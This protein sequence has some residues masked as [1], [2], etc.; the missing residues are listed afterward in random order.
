V[1][2]AVGV[3]Y[4]RSEWTAI[5]PAIQK[6]LDALKKLGDGEFRVDARTLDDKTWVVQFVRS[7]SSGKY[8][9]YDRETGTAKVWI[10]TRPALKDAPLVTMHPQEIKSRDGLTLVSYLSL[11][12]NSDENNDGKPEQ[13]VPMVLLVH[14]GPW[15]RDGFGLNRT[16]QWLANRGYAVLSVNYRASTGFGKKFLNA[17]NLEWGKKMHDDLIDAVDWAVKGGIT[18]QD[19]VAIMGGSYGGYATLA[20]LTM[21]PKTF[22]CGVDIVGPSNLFTLL[23][24]IPPYWASFRK[25]FYTRMGDPNTDE[26]K[27]ILKDRSPLTYADKIE[28]PLLIGQGQNDPRVNVAEVAADRGRDEGEEHPGD[29][30]RVSGRGPRL[31]ASAQQHLVQLDRRELPGQ[32]PGRPLGADRRGL[33]GLEHHHSRGREPAAGRGRS[34]GREPAAGAGGRSEAR[35]H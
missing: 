15:A 21:T 13:P 27:A 7:D 10:D 20:G 29:L 4:L 30:R 31:R 8:Y 18:S 6:D 3:N 5:D 23:N 12:K 1:V 24:S 17:G 9:L 33:Q 35:G 25:Q 32:V 14:G 16:H 34:V 2:Q 26:G 19:K 22:A 28:R 11:P